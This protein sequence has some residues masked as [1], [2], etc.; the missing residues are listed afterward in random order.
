MTLQTGDVYR[1]PEGR[2][3]T[4]TRRINPVG[5][6]PPYCAVIHYGTG[7]T[8]TIREDRLTTDYTPISVREDN[9]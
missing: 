9:Q 2:Q 7:R 1:D 5:D 6:T 3:F 8:T 4:F